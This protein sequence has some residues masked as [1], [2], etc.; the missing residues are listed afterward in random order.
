VLVAHEA[1]VQHAEAYNRR[2]V[3]EGCHEYRIG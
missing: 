2:W 1:A 3:D